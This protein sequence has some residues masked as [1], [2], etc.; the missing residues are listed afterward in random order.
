MRKKSKDKRKGREWSEL[1]EQTEAS[2]GEGS[3]EEGSGAEA[4]SPKKQGNSVKN[5]GQLLEYGNIYKEQA[6]PEGRIDDIFCSDSKQG[7]RKFSCVSHTAGCRVPDTTPAPE[8]TVY[9][10]RG[11]K[12]SSRWA[13][14]TG[15]SSN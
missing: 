9:Y 6:R 3:E 2:S 12:K 14:V 5:F 10:A 7:K 4:S 1:P 8:N 11:K 15:F 13:W